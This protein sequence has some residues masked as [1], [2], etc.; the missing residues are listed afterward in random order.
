MKSEQWE[1][2]FARIDKFDKADVQNVIQR[3][4][5]ERQLLESIFSLLKEAILIIKKNGEVDYAND[6]AVSLLGID[7]SKNLIFWKLSPELANIASASCSEQNK[8]IMLSRELLLTYPEKRYVRLYMQPFCNREEKEDRFV[9]ILSDVTEE[10]LHTEKLIEDEKIASVLQVASEVAHEIGN[11]LNSIQI[12][13]QLLQKRINACSCQKNDSI[14]YSIEVC[15]NEFERLNKTVKNFLNTVRSQPLKCKKQ[16]IIPILEKTIAVL[17]PQLEGLD[18]KVDISLRNKLEP[19]LIDEDKI[20]QIFFNLIKNSIEAIGNGGHLNITAQSCENILSLS[21][22]DSGKGF[23][24]EKA[25]KLFKSGNQSS[26]HEGQ[27]IGMLVVHKIMKEHG[28]TVEVLSKSG[29]GSVVT[30]KFPI[31]QNRIKFLKSS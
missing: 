4:V 6:S 26:K 9:V 7:L 31:E 13:L 17:Q 5:R 14:N 18:I 15:L 24:P 10:K 23:A 16:D 22:A 25:A 19:I 20:Q 30:L 1:K 2:V 29:T 27:G 11:P 21:F 28:G 8:D 3:L 12:H